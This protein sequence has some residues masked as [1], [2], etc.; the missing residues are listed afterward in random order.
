V[1]SVAGRYC[2]S[3]IILS[4]AL[5]QPLIAFGSSIQLSASYSIDIIS[6][7]KKHQDQV[8]FDGLPLA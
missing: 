6:S 3:L 5:G 1:I 8:E 7:K 2:F 4:L